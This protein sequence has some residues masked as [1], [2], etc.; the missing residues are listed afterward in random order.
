MRFLTLLV[1]A[2]LTLHAAP[3]P[4][5]WWRPPLTY[6]SLDPDDWSIRFSIGMPPK[7]TQNPAGPGWFF[8]FPVHATASYDDCRETICV[9]PGPES[10]AVSCCESIHYLTVPYVTALPAGQSL[11]ATID[12]VTTGNAVFLYDTEPGNTCNTPATVRFFVQ[13]LENKNPPPYIMIDEHARWWSNPVALVLQDTGGP[14][15]LTAPIDP[16]QWSNVSGHK[17]DFNADTLAG[18]N[19]AMQDH[20]GIGFTFGGGCFFGHGVGLAAG[21]TARFTLSDLRVE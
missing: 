8:D 19:S 20:N 16:A 21:G 4:R 5:G 2:S 9:T 10:V 11:K 15:V 1:L 7:P 17:G 12:I 3:K 6:I 18:F 13:V 14:V